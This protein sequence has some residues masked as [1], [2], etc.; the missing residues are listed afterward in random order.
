MAENMKDSTFNVAASTGTSV[1]EKVSLKEGKEVSSFENI[2][3]VST[4]PERMDWK[5]LSLDADREHQS[6]AQRDDTIVYPSGLKL[7][8][9]AS[10]S[11]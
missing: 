1:D 7:F 6:I 3:A 9:L 10:V 5:D 11:H 4:A 8:L 2:P